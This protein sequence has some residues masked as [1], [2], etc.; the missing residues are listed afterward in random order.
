MLHQVGL[1]NFND[2]VI[3][4]KEPVLVEFFL[5]DVRSLPPDQAHP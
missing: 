1:G 4:S 3:D 5:P 2:E